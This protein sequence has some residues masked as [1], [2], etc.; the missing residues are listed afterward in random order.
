MEYPFDI[1]VVV[2][3]FNE[4]ESLPELVRWIKRVMHAHG[5]SYE[6]IL[7]DDGS[8]DRSWEVV[9]DLS[10]EDN[11]VKGIS[12]NRNYGK[13][14]ALNEGFKRCAG[15]VVI[16]MDADLQDSPDEIPALYDIIKNQKYDMVSGWKKKRFDPLSKT[17][18]TKLFNA[19]TRKL[20]GI[21]LHDF[22]CGLKA[23]RQLVV[24]SIEVHGEMHRYIPVIAKWHGFTRITER[25]VQH[26]ER[27]YGTTKFGLER[28]VYGFLDLLSITFVSRFKKRPMHFF[29]SL[30]T[31]MF[32]VGLGITF[33]LIMQKIF[34]LYSDG[35]VRDVVDQPLFYLSLVAVILGVQLFLA[36][37]LAEMISMSSAKRNEYLIKD[38]T[39]AIRK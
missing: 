18:P 17:I 23:Y 24:K 13:S 11:A 36:G 39:G 4:E 35:R 38:K 7:V 3:L 12:F 14:A 1:S 22:N 15:E 19:A 2:P 28:F 33:W 21:Q 29:G 26:Q 10:A 20:S 37:F 6:I 8:T 34:R 9:H 32:L 31:L 5:F 27:K 16:T 30:G 25:V